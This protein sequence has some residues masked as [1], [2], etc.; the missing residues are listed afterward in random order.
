MAKL[1]ANKTSSRRKMRKAHF[2]ASSVERRARMAAPLSKELF[3][4][5]H[6]RSLPL[7]KDD[8]VRVLRGGFKGKEG[9]IVQCYRKKYVVHVERCTRDKANGQTIH[10]GIDA[11][12]V[13]ITKVKMDKSRKAI[14]DR[15]NRAKIGQS[16]GDVTSTLVD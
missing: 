15:K 4:R 3:M 16:K 11:S 2:G 14:L 9:K 10:V 8:E 5:H 7:R 12:N 1:N 13:E 6:V